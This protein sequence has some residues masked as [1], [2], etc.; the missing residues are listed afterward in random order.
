MKF[1]LA[2]VAIAIGGLAVPAAAQQAVPQQAQAASQ[3]QPS[4]K[5]QAAILALQTAVKAHDTANI[6]AKLAAAQAVAST[7]ADRYWIA[8]LQLQAAVANSNFPAAQQALDAIAGTNVLPASR[9][10]E[11]YTGLGGNYLK[12]K[13][14]DQAVSAFEKASSLAPTD[15]DSVLL[16][17]QA[18]LDQ[19]RKAEAAAA[20]QRALQISKA[21][22]QKPSE[23]IYRNAVALA[24]E[25]NLPG[26]IGLARE[27]L[28][29]YP[30][31]EAWRNSVAIY[32]NLNHGDPDNII[33]VMRLAQLTNAMQTDTDY[34][35][36]ASKTVDQGNFAEAKAAIDA[37][38]AAGKLKATNPEV[39]QFIAAT[40]GKVPTAAELAAAEKGAV[41][42][43]AFLR[44]GDRYYAAGD[45]TKATAL[46]REA[47]SKGV[48]SNLAN[49][50]IG[51]ALAR[52]GD[53]AGATAAFNAVGGSR[54]DLGKFWLLYLQTHG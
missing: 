31:D 13:Q 17:A 3:P 46:Y 52:A 43:N 34:E 40:K 51:E 26:S 18:R 27:W 50:R 10:A 36:Y 2:A 33:D 16:V 24:Y 49:L 11:L 21:A 25:A 42:P 44:V 14:Y 15:A 8:Q 20:M 48:D 22:G 38:I 53:K 32:R 39:K 37:G 12:A 28:T 35:I 45:Y 7:P 19:G 30:S 29:A 6:P 5:A 1:P 41:A 47:L 23:D 54:S 9:L 4:A